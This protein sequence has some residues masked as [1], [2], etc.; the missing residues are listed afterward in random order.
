[1][2]SVDQLLLGYCDESRIQKLA[3]SRDELI[4]GGRGEIKAA[5]W[6]A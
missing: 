3:P 4:N 1:L 6:Y 5:V 2:Q